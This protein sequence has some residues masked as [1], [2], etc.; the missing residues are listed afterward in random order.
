MDSNAF[1]QTLVAEEEEVGEEE[2]ED[3]DP[4]ADLAHRVDTLDRLQVRR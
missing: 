1:L 3:L 2:A 4:E